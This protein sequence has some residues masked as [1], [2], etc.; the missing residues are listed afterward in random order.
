ML[1]VQIQT[2]A[3]TLPQ[4]TSSHKHQSTN[5]IICC[6]QVS[7]GS[8]QGIA[9]LMML[10]YSMYDLVF[11]AKLGVIARTLYRAAP[12]LMHYAF[13]SIVLVVGV[14]MASHCTLGAWLPAFATV[15]GRNSHDSFNMNRI[16]LG[17]GVYVAAEPSN[18][19][20]SHCY[21]HP[22]STVTTGLLWNEKFVHHGGKS[23]PLSAPFCTHESHADVVII[24]MSISR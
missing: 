12:D 11:D 23:V 6:V 13:L 5:Y 24:I 9:L 15:S 10:G 1:L 8:L 19:H 18:T 3:A 16:R 20:R 17:V 21:D 22:D 14:T 2:T 4:V 7:Y